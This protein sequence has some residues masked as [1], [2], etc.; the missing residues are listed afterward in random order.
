MTSETQQLGVVATGLVLSVNISDGGIPKL[1]RDVVEITTDGL[2]GDA[3]NHDK[4]NTPLQ[5]V[6]LIDHEDLNDLRVEGYPLVAGSTG[7]N[8]TL[9]GM[10]IDR[11]AIGDLVRFTGGVELELTKRR[12]PCYV[13]DAI[14]PS[15]K[16]A[17]KGRCGFYAKVLTPGTIK[18]GETATLHR[19]RST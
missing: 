11:G 6:S 16:T 2:R 12:N 17:I 3:H 7:E 8:I 1:P 14:D 5:A 13:L 18:P 10:Q 4:H 19:P 9:E 15:L